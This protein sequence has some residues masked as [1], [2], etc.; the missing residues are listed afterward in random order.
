MK[1]SLVTGLQAIV[2]VPTCAN[3]GLRRIRLFYRITELSIIIYIK[4]IENL[5]KTTPNVKIENMINY[6]KGKKPSS[7]KPIFIQEDLKLDRSQ[8]DILKKILD[9]IFFLYGGLSLIHISEHTRPDRSGGGGV[10]GDK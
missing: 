6:L 10:V 8:T 1:F 4:E 5:V 7:L 9:Q 2:L 3:I